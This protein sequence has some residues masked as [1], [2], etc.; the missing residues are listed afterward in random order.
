MT[1]E[2]DRASSRGD[3]KRDRT[4]D[5]V[6]D[7]TRERARSERRDL[8]KERGE[9]VAGA[10]ARGR[11]RP[12][13]LRAIARPLSDWTSRPRILITNDDGVESRGLLALKQALD[14]IGDTTVVA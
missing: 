14:P 5:D 10:A 3:E 7:M 2:E 6:P 12:R 11:G 8:D 13:A 4:R 1:D 9:P